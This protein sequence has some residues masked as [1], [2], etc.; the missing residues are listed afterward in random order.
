MVDFRYYLNRQGPRGQQGVKGEQGYSPQVIVGKNTASEFTLKVINEDGS[1]ETENLK[2]TAEDRGGT[3]IRYDRDTYQ[4]YIGDPD[5][6]STEKYRL[7]RVATKED[8]V[9]QEE[10]RAVTSALLDTYLQEKYFNKVHGDVVSGDVSFRALTGF[11]QPIGVHG[12]R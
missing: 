4:E 8:L 10:S 12:L 9:S 3:Y 11:T 5:L 6:A 2:A 1:F 7:V